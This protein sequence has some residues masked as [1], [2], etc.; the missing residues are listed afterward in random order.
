MSVP[1][2]GVMA[3]QSLKALNSFTLVVA[4]T[5]AIFWNTLFLAVHKAPSPVSSQGSASMF[6]PKENLLGPQ[7][8]SQGGVRAQPALLAEGEIGVQFRIPSLDLGVK[9][10]MPLIRGRW[11]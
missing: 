2:S 4:F 1:V 8:H 11:Y 6:L 5:E 3:S 7:R 9:C 10:N